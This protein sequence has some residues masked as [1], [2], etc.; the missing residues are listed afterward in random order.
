MKVFILSFLLIF[1]VQSQNSDQ[2]NNLPGLPY[3]PKFNHYAGYISVDDV[4]GRS[5]FYWFTESQGN[6]SKDPVVVWLTGGPGCSSLLAL[7]SENGPYFPTKDANLEYN[8]FSWNRIANMLWIESP[9]G[10]GFSYSNRTSDYT[11][12]D[13]RTSQ[14]SYNFLVSF[15]QKYPQFKGNDFWITGESYGG[16]Y[17]P[18]L[19]QRIVQG[20]KKNPDQKINIQG[21]LA[22]NAWTYMPFENLAAVD[23]WWQRGLV[24]QQTCED[25]KTYCNLS[26]EGPLASSQLDPVKCEKAIDLSS[27]QMGDVSIYNIYADVCISNE[28]KHMV[29]QFANS[30]SISHKL[31]SSKANQVKDAEPCIENF[32][33]AYLNRPDVQ[34]AV[35]IRNPVQKWSA[36]S[37]KVHYN[38]DDIASSVIPVY[39]F[40]FNENLKIL[41]YAGDVDAIVPYSGSLAWIESLK[42]NI[43]DPWR[44]WYDS[45]KQVGGYVTVYE[46][47]TFTTVRGAGHMVPTFQPT[48][49]L[50]MLSSFMKTG[51]LPQ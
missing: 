19:A 18:Q 22:G 12:G 33:T 37:N 26:Y 51:K 47:L 34:K 20:N 6:P 44:P 13:D 42:M 40:L 21:F 27:D 3:Q 10:V 43:T 15:F 30:G 38:Y 48:R 9:A 41:V 14:D 36:C 28:L 1:I 29:S 4:A 24:P 7:F 50:M 35:N 39:Q 16:H 23:T 49:A 8:S 17:I 31:L 32:M 45:G 46:S 11:V 2:I 25:I 5:L